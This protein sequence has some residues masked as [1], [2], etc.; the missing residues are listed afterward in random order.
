M[1]KVVGPLAAE[2]PQGGLQLGGLLLKNEF[3]NTLSAASGLHDVTPLAC[4]TVVQRPRFRYE[5]PLPLLLDALR[6]L[7]TLQP[8]PSLSSEDSW[9]RSQHLPAL[10]WQASSGGSA[11]GAEAESVAAV[12]AAAQAVATETT[13]A[14][15]ASKQ[16][17]RVGEAITL[18]F[19][20]AERCLTLEWEASPV[21]DLLGDAVTATLLQSQAVPL[22]RPT[23]IRPQLQQLLPAVTKSPGSNSAAKV[24]TAVLQP[25]NAAMEKSTDQHPASGSEALR[26]LLNVHFGDMP[27]EVAGQGPLVHDAVVE[28]G[29]VEA[30]QRVGALRRLDVASIVGRDAFD[31]LILYNRLISTIDASRRL[32]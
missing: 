3:T 14:D 27:L 20:T 23:L 22:P 26:R 4:T 5:Q 21:A 6:S 2:P 24:D 28:C 11:A 7:F 15:E 29:N 18:S 30:T 19:V 32:C 8:L 12:A 25:A 13:E 1:T 9:S 10:P 17:W 31:S 16:R